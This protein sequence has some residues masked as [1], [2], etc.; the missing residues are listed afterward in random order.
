M[1]PFLALSE[2][3]RG[4][5]AKNTVDVSTLPSPAFLSH[6]ETS[7]LKIP[8][9]LQKSKS[10]Q[11]DQEEKAHSPSRNRTGSALEERGRQWLLPPVR[12]LH[13]Y[14]RLRV[15]SS[16]EM[17]RYILAYF[18]RDHHIHAGERD[19]KPSMVLHLASSIEKTG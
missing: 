18:L 11:Q 1:S 6:H 15:A 17:K 19:A 7:V 2:A 8:D 9:D 10:R 14:L 13:S 5:A 3:A 4:V 12:I 16:D